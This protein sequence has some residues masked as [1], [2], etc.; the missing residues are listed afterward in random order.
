MGHEFDRESSLPTSYRISEF[1]SQITS[2][3]LVVEQRSFLGHNEFDV[4]DS[5]NDEP[6]YQ[7]EHVLISEAIQH[8][9]SSVRGEIW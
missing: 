7:H 3:L 4:L 5:E 1:V 6:W 2:L 8:V 9:P